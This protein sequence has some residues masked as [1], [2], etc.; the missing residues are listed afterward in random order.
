MASTAAGK[1]RAA[2]RPVSIEVGV[3]K[4]AEGSALIK[5][6]DT[7]VLVSASIEDRV[8]PF[9]KMAGHGWLTAEYG[10]LPRSTQQRKP[11]ESTLGKVGGRTMEIQRLIGRALRSVVDLRAL[12]E[13]T[14][15]IDCDVLQADGGT[16]TA[17]ITA[18]FVAL[19]EA[20]GCLLDRGLL[21]KMPISDFVAAVSVGVVQEQPVLDLCYGED[22]GAKVDMNVVMTAAGK[23]VEVQGTGEQEPFSFDEMG[24][25][26]RL[27]EGGIK[28]LIAI[29]RETL[30][31][32]GQQVGRGPGTG[33]A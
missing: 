21:Q 15:W 17:S 7:H 2:L 9:A 22:A 30:G 28:Q 5:Q 4:Y 33:H 6:G 24:E 14:I 13:R 12:G 23:V 3:M 16:R 20:C 27:A 26:L 29:Q 25:L 31:P 10:M 8:P 32:L 18:A 11:R 1:D 19:T